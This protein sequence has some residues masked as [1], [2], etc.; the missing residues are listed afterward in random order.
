MDRQAL[1]TVT[2]T[3]Y[4]VITPTEKPKWLNWLILGAVGLG[5]LF[6]FTRGGTKV[7]V[8]KST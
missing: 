7:V 1:G 8:V 5:A 6:F 3:E 2:D 4:V